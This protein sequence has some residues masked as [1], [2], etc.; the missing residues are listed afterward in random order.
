LVVVAAVIVYS[1]L[2]LS[3]PFRRRVG[4]A[5]RLGGGGLPSSLGWLSSQSSQSICIKK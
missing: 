1:G 3:S 2:R 5:R 4:R